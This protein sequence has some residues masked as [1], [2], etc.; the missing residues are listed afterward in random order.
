M[1]NRRHVTDG[2]DQETGSLQGAQSRFTTGTRTAHFHFEGAHAVLGSFFRSVFRSNLGSIRSG[3]T[4]TFETESTSGRPGDRVALC[5][6]DRDHGV[7]E[8]GVHMRNARRDVLAFAATH[9]RRVF[10]HSLILVLISSL[11]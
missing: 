4:G 5:V 1:R 3:L 9:A 10:S 6:G 7:I 2:R 11:P 8:R